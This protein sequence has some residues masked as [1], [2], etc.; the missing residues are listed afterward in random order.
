MK[1][2]LAYV[3][4]AF[5][6][7]ANATTGDELFGWLIGKDE[8]LLNRAQGYIT[9][10]VEANQYRQATDEQ[11]EEETGITLSPLQDICPPQNATMAQAYNIVEE[12][13]RVLVA[14]RNGP[15]AQLVNVSLSEAWPCP[16]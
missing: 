13:L 12:S 15:A 10:V 3:L 5:A 9:A 6:I 11:L 8:Q 7:Q 16:Q 4:C 14:H 2:L 1:H